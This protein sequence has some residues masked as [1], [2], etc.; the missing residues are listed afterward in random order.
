MHQILTD[1]NKKMESINEKSTQFRELLKSCIENLGII[2]SKKLDYVTNYAENCQKKL[3]FQSYVSIRI[4]KAY[5]TFILA[6]FMTILNESCERR[7]FDTL[8]QHTR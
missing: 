2:A 5:K 7:I 3:L 1:L 4:K 8:K 6:R